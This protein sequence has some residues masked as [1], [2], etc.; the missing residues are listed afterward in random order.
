MTHR[1][2][3][4]WAG[5]TLAVVLLSGAVAAALAGW[6]S[7][8]Q[9]RALLDRL[10]SSEPRER[11]DAF[12]EARHTTRSEVVRRM[13]ETFRK[14]HDP[15]VLS[16]AAYAIMYT[17]DPRGLP[18]LVQRAEAGPDS[19]VRAEMM[20]YI[21]RH[22]SGDD[23]RAAWMR[24]RLATDEP[25]LRTGAAAGLLYLGR[26]EGGAQLIALAREGTPEHRAFALA[27]LRKVVQPMTEA[28]A[29]PIA[30]P[31]DGPVDSAEPFWEDLAGFWEVHGRTRLLDDVLARLFG[32][33][34][35]WRELKR[36]LHA[37][38][39]AERLLD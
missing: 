14:E 22:E 7:R 33:D 31:E 1:R 20:V 16:K 23:S 38:E 29:W 32:D 26:P 13:L 30:W 8:R 17:K 35:H 3:I 4:T 2:W 11:A 25:W 5:G 39:Y 34:P 28:V 15:T 27:Q 6:H 21:A 9:E 19:E 18:L 36:L 37:R 12:Y 10:D 24:E